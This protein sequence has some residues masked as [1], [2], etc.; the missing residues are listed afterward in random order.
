MMKTKGVFLI[1]LLCAFAFSGMAQMRTITGTVTSSEDSGPL[2][3]A[4][5]SEKGGNSGVTTD[6]NG[7]YSITV[8]QNATT[9]VFKFVGFKTVEKE[10]GSNSSIDLSLD[11]DALK[12]DEVVVTALGISKDKRALGYAVS[13]ITAEDM[14]NSGEQNVIQSLAAKAPGIQVIGSGGVPG[15]SSKILIR[16]NSTFTNENQPLIIVDGVPINNATNNT[17]GGDYPF[18]PGLGGVPNSN[19]ALDLNPEDIESV[20]VLKGAAAAALYGVRAGNGAI[21]YTTKRGKGGY[22]GKGVK[23]T[24]SSKVTLDQV[25]KLPELQDEWAQGSGGGVYDTISPTYSFAEG[26]P[27]LDGEWFTADDV[28]YGTSNSW[29]PA[30][31]DLGEHKDVPGYHTNIDSLMKSGTKGTVEPVDNMGDFFRTGVTWQNNLAVVGGNENSSF[32]LSLGNTKQNGIVPNTDFKRTS[33]RITTDTRMNDKLSVGTT[34]NYINSGGT[35]AQ[36]GSNLSGVM[37]GLTRAPAQYSLAGEGD[38]GY[39]FANGK[40]RQYFYP[41]DNPYWT[42]YENPFTDDINRVLGNMNVRY[43]PTKWL[44]LSYRLGTDFY[45]D[46]RKQVFAIGSWDPPNPTGQ[47]EDNTKRSREVYQDILATVSRSLTDKLDARVTVGNN[48]YQNHAQDVYARGRDL[49]VPGN[50]NLS[51][52]SDLYAS[53]TTSIYRTYAFFYDGNLDWDRWLYFNFTGRYENSSTYG[54]NSPKFNFFPS[55]SLSTIFSKFIP[56]NDIFSYGKLRASFAQVGINPPNY[57]AAT[58]FVNPFFTDGF[59]DGLSLPYLGVNGFGYSDIIGDNALAPELINEVEIGTDLRFWNGRLN[60]DITYY[61]KK[62]SQLLVQRPIAPST[63]FE[64]QRSNFGEMVNKGW[65]IMA[66]GSPIESKDFKW[67][68]SVNFTKNTNEVLLLDPEGLVSE[69]DIETAFS[70]IHS[71]AV[72]GNAYGQLYGTVWEKNDNGDLIINPNTG[73]PIVAQLE[74]PLGNPFPDW[75]MGIRNNFN[76]KGVTVSALLDIRQGGDVWCGTCARLN[77]LGRTEASAKRDENYT[78]EGVLAEVDAVTG[79]VVYTDPD[80]QGVSTV[81][82]TSSANNVEVSANR[83]WT[84]FKGDAGAAVEESVQD[85]SWVR[86][87]EVSAA[88]RLKLADNKYI[89]Y[90]DFTISARNLWLKTKYEGVDPETSLLGAGSNI[91]G[92][93]YFNMPGTKSYTFGISVGF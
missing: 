38:D 63:G 40:Q 22:A 3:G 75:T 88:Y 89:Q 55:F 79:A 28:D 64:A 46:Q 19:R 11:V 33:V 76:Y 49:S 44:N 73:L 78:I 43:N 5:I 12:L 80:D 24:F 51:N 31:S 13:E 84:N 56:E 60:L 67:N 27:G 21:V 54:I 81:V 93:D 83:Y 18:N 15:A 69:I 58:Y 82:P 35:K 39:K 47:I 6:V 53:E 8:D 71:Y 68:I 65:E 57:S 59:T 20:T 92:F 34:I 61:N 23:V 74:A 87:R 10:I 29:G 50:F 2:P 41:Y 17:V 30:I 32:R 85:G 36:N 9:L 52:A 16:G 91:N 48:I 4:T 14:A 77:R 1:M 66:S 7:K 25:N 26:N 42:V 90:I 70:S 45:T 86:L 62:S 72:V 37:L